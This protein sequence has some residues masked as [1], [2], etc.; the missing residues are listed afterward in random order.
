MVAQTLAGTVEEAQ[1]LDERLRF[2][3]TARTRVQRFVGQGL[4]RLYRCDGLLPLCYSQK[5]DYLRE[6]LGL[7]QREAQELV[8]I[9]RRIGQYPE[10]QRFWEEGRINR[11]HVRELVGKVAPEDDFMWARLASVM[12][13]RE[14]QERLGSSDSDA[15]AKGRRLEFDASPTLRELLP[16]AQDVINAMHGSDI[17]LIGCV[18]TCAMEWHS[19]ARSQ[20]FQQ[21]HDDGRLN[22]RALLAQGLA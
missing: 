19:T 22:T 2:L 13:V 3:V 15:D 16:V 21:M 1:G 7:G 14:L 17:G 5:K 6:R 11:C 4:D 12:T 20:D 18:D 8:L 9:E 10:I